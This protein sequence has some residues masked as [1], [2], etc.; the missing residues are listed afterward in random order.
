MSDDLLIK[1]IDGCCTPAEAEQVI[2]EL[3][4]QGSGAAEWVQMVNASRLADTPALEPAEGAREYVSAVLQRKEV[5]R[6]KVV[7]LSAVA[8][9]L[10][11]LAAS[12]AI[13]FVYKG[14]DGY[15]P[16]TGGSLA[17]AQDSLANSLAADTLIQAPVQETPDRPAKQMLQAESVMQKNAAL[18]P[19]AVPEPV[20]SMELSRNASKAEAPGTTEASDAR[21]AP[22]ST[23]DQPKP[24]IAEHQLR[25]TRPAKS[26][27][28]V[29]VKDL[30][31]DFVFEWTVEGQASRASLVVKDSKGM[32]L[33]DKSTETP[34]ANSFPIGVMELTDRGEL[35]WTLVLEFTDGQKV[36][37]TG[38]LEMKSETD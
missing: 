35:T 18:T 15:V 20:L 4:R 11:A 14:N 8:G 24:Q 31:K 22:D 13:F 26:P 7:R 1:F 36:S 12:F 10:C 33:V 6:K 27:Y 25:M 32:T 9:V 28:R 38:R 19:E 29:K 37:R 2:G 23:A 34:D 3:S 5:S 17:C 16:Q 21:T 30:T